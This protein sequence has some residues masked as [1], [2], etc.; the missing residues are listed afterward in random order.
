MEANKMKQYFIP[1]KLVG[2]SF[3]NDDGI[4]RQDLIKALKEGEKL[5]IVHEPMNKFD[6]NCHAVLNE[7]G[8]VLGNISKELA[9]DLMA[10]KGHMEKILGISDWKV[11]GLDQN[12]LGLNIQILLESPYN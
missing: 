2:V 4:K 10:K 1:T 12:T 9:M 11:T 8:Q 7:N 5:T 6:A 3:P